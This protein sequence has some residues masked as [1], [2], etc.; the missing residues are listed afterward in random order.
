MF[1]DPLPFGGI[2]VRLRWPSGKAIER[3]IAAF[4]LDNLKERLDEAHYRAR[5]SPAASERGTGRGH[6]ELLWGTVRLNAKEHDWLPDHLDDET[7]LTLIFVGEEEN[8]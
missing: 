1:K 5:G 7:E 2:W 8:I 4:A 6:Y 3:R